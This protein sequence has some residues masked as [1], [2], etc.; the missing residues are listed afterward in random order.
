MP[1]ATCKTGVIAR[2][3]LPPEQAAWPPSK[4]KGFWKT[5]ESKTAS[6]FGGIQMARPAAIC[7][8]RGEIRQVNPSGRG[9]KECLEMGDTCVHL[10][11]RLSCGHIGC[12]DSS[13]NKHATK[14]FRQTKHPL[15]Q[16]F[17]P[18]E[19]WRGCYVDEVFLE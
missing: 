6:F 15:V 9:C 12:C 3:S 18:G 17:E 5:R 4:P 14:H 13:K 7:S 10:R 16:S 1:A 19:D 2:R 11:E 8:H